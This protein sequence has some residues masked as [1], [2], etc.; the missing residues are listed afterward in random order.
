MGGVRVDTDALAWDVIDQVG[1]GGN[2]LSERHTLR[3]LRR[4]YYFSQ[5][6]N[7]LA[8]ETWAEAGALDVR[9][10]ASARVQKLLA[11][12]VEPVLP[13]EVIRELRRVL[14]RAQEDL[15]S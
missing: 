7:R 5:T 13:E 15:A 2:Y 3:Y 6:A 11:E 4:E 1:P 14:D 9:A 10:R 12:P 8:P